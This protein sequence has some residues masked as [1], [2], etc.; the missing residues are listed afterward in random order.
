MF[1]FFSFQRHM[2]NGRRSGLSV[3]TVYG[4][5]SGRTV[6]WGGRVARWSGRQ[7]RGRLQAWRRL[8]ID[9][10]EAQ[11]AG[12]YTPQLPV[13]K[14]AQTIPPSVRPSIPPAAVPR[15]SSSTRQQLT[16]SCTPPW[17]TACRRNPR[18][19]HNTHPAH[20]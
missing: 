17:P 12:H 14:N 7:T 19:D 11:F 20:D 2:A 5:W 4:W 8:T 9:Q 18:R 6:G 10:A 3:W 13:T 15:R 16:P 1:F